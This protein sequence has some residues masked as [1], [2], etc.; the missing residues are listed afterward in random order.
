MDVGQATAAGLYQ[1][2]AAGTFRIEEGAARRC[3]ECF[4][5]FT[6]SLEEMITDSN[7]LERSSGFG[8]FVSSQQLAQGFEGK[9]REL[10][11]ALTGLKEAAF[12]MAAAYLQAG[13][14]IEEAEQMNQRAI[15]AATAGKAQ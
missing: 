13:G 14:L 15:M 9:G 4:F 5:R 11:E 2:A 1:Q 8:G 7:N 10:T 6:D 3:A 12:R